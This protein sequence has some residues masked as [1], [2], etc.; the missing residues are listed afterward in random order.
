MLTTLLVGLSAGGGRA[1]DV[2]AAK[3]FASKALDRAVEYSV[4]VPAGEAPAGGWPL[5][6]LLHGAGRHHRSL[7]D[8]PATREV[9]LKQKFVIVFADGKG[10]WY[11]D[12]PVDPKSR[13][14]SML[15][16]LLE[17]SR[18]TLPI[19]PR[20]EQTGICGW[21]MGG[22]GTMR[23]AQT[24]PEEF[25]AVATTIALLDFPNPDLPKNQNYTVP[26]VFGTDPEVWAKQ[27]CMAHVERL[28]GKS[29]LIVS[30]DRAFDTQMNRNF[31]AKLEAAGI[32]HT[33][34]EVDGGHTFAVVQATV[35]MMFAFFAERFR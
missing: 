8:D 27:T 5:V 11:L 28:R 20:P 15:R 24:F 4:F 10:G 31:H 6:L 19:S 22:Y 26:K 12:S 18:K 1:D 14:Q 29:I 13:Y 9:I 32:A 34:R 2:I 33:Y 35:P 23:F 16:E 17:H 3:S 25:A 7:A 21:S 30:G